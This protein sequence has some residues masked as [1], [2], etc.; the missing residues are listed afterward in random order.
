MIMVKFLNKIKWLLIIGAVC[1]AA[2]SVGLWGAGRM[3]ASS[4]AVQ[5][6]VES[7][8]ATLPVKSI[9]SSKEAQAGKPKKEEKKKEE[10]KKETVEK[11]VP[12]AS[13][14]DI[15]DPFL[16][17]FPVSQSSGTG[18]TDGVVAQ[19]FVLQGVV[20]SG[21]NSIALVDDNVFSLGDYIYGWKVIGIKKDRIG[22]KKDKEI[23]KLFLKWEGQ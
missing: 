9:I 18:E 7:P 5:P 19:S 4:P 21:K 12:V 14:K 3:S 23:K 11:K 17:D 16:V 6:A 20:L 8:A 10:K 1:A 15:P 2:F 13:L 22:L